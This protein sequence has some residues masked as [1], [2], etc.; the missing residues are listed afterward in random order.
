M[1]TAQP[2]NLT[3]LDNGLRLINVPMQNS[4]SIMVLV[5]VGTGSRYETKDVNGI[6]H[7]L[8]HMMFKGTL[9][10][11]GALDI[12][13]ELDSIGADNN[14]FTSKEYTGY[15]AKAASNNLDQVLDIISDIF[16]N[17]KIDPV[18]VDK[19]RGVIIEEINMRRD[20]PQQHVGNMFE[21]LLYGDQPLGWEISGEKETIQT[22]P[23]D[24]FVEYFD[25]HYFAENTVVVVAGKF[26]ESTIADKVRGYFSNVRR[27]QVITPLPVQESQ[28]APAISTFEKPTDQSHF[29]VGVRAYD[30]FN[31]NNYPLRVMSVILGSGMSSRLFD[32][33]REKRGLAYYVYSSVD[34]FAD[35]GYFAASAG[36]NSSKLD[37]SIKVILHEFSKLTKE[38]VSEKELTKAKNYIRGKMLIHMET[39]DSQASFY[40]D[41][42]LLK[43]KIMTT[44]EIL[45]RLDAVTASDILQVAQ[46]ILKSQ[47]LNLAIVGPKIKEGSLY[48]TL[49][50]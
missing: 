31:D 22:M 12:T 6:S 16:Q 4:E 11:P 1:S 7:F 44:D 36:V 25:T 29:I 47:T 32:E 45:A 21:T 5:L 46:E 40:G 49:K 50:L 15:Y 9:K 2:Y 30:R 20:D 14:A 10:R 19:E 48:N 41:Q 17:S 28:Q 43:R 18:E 24:K 42:E 38:P 33:V 26:D 34:S 8:E 3:T 27:H 37:E 39:S 35:T 23:R 13:H